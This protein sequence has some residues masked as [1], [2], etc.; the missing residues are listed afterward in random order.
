MKNNKTLEALGFENDYD[1]T[2]T[3]DLGDEVVLSYYADDSS[4]YLFNEQLEE[5]IKSGVVSIEGL[6]S[7]I[8]E[9]KEE[10]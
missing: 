5:N 10:K 8:E 6:K 3:L 1:D 2:W 4:W 7:L 9:L